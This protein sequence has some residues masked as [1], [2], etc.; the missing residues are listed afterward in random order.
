MDE[1]NLLLKR[2]TTVKRDG[3][4]KVTPDYNENKWFVLK[5]IGITKSNILS[6]TSS[7]FYIVGFFKKIIVIRWG[8]AYG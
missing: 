1:K 4:Y 8:E 6:K 3:I 5:L 7:M 2:N